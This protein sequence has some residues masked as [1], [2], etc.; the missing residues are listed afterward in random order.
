MAED[1]VARIH[2]FGGDIVLSTDASADKT[3]TQVIYG[4]PSTVRVYS[5]LVGPVRPAIFII[6][7]G[8]ERRAKHD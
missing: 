6:A 7:P 8:A 3:T 1:V 2:R 5:G 4:L